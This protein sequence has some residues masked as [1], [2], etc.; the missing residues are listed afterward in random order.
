MQVK[1]PD[2]R[3]KIVSWEGITCIYLFN[4]HIVNLLVRVNGGRDR[5]ANFVIFVGVL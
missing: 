3:S 4:S 1:F 2:Q 5:R